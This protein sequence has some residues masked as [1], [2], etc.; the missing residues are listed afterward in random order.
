MTFNYKFRDA[1]KT[2]WALDLK[3]AGEERNKECG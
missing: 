3:V 1:L 2:I